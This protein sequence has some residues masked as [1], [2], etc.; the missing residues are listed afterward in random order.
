MHGHDAAEDSQPETPRDAPANVT[1]LLL[2]GSSPA[3]HKQSSDLESAM[4]PREEEDHSPDTQLSSLTH[5]T[6]TEL[7]VSRQVIC[8][9]WFVM[10]SL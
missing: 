2:S 8:H 9:C 5:D 4:P 3:R 10:Y 1:T 6:P 7:S